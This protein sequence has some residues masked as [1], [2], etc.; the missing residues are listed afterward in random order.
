MDYGRI[1]SIAFAISTIGLILLLSRSFTQEPTLLSSIT[2]DNIGSRVYVKGQVGGLRPS[3]DGH[4]F[5]QLNDEMGTIKVVVFSDVTKKLPCI[6]EGKN[7][8]MRATVQDYRGEIEL[9]PSKA[10]YVKC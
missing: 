6:L 3:P 2:H 10:T 1:L 8:E 4:L 9:I 7:I 5:F